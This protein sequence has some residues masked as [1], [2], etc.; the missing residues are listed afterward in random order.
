MHQDWLQFCA[1]YQGLAQ[2][3]ICIGQLPGGDT[4]ANIAKYSQLTLSV[5][6]A[7]LQSAR[8][9]GVYL[10][11][12]GEAIFDEGK[13][14]SSMNQMV[15]IARS[16]AQ[17]NPSVLDYS[18]FVTGLTSK[19]AARSLGE[20]LKKCHINRIHTLPT[21]TFTHQGKG[22]KLEGKRTYDQLAQALDRLM[23]GLKNERIKNRVT[24][25]SEWSILQKSPAK[26]VR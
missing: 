15:L 7:A 4:S 20:D 11:R 24:G 22:I 5:K 16:L 10:A 23:P 26:L 9:A 14:L 3:K 6:A 25:L 1:D 2:F 8:A 19:E 18:R 13:D 12:L 17:K 21:V